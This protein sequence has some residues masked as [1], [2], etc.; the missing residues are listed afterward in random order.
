[1]NNVKE[2][3]TYCDARPSHN[4]SFVGESSNIRVF[5]DNTVAANGLSPTQFFA[6]NASALKLFASVLLDCA[7]TFSLARNTLHIFY[8]SAGSTIA[9][10]QN[11]ALFFNYRYF[12]NLHLP[13]VQQDR[14]TDAIAYWCVVMAHELA[15]NLVSDHSAQHSYYTESMVI[16]YFGR[17][18]AKIAGQRGFVNALPSDP[19]EQ[20]QLSDAS[21]LSLD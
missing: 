5:L 20:G 3:A 1:M 19:L 11:K 13:Q 8:D 18:A 7:D 17:I 10:N 15:H 4:I 21:H 16:Q 9:F 2:T 14:R 6:T 12:E